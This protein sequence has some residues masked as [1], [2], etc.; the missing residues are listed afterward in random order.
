MWDIVKYTRGTGLDLGCG[1]QKTFPHFIG[2]D[3]C[4]DTQLFGIAMKPDVQVKTCERLDDFEDSACDF[5]FSSHLLEHIED[6]EAALKE[7]W[8][9]IRN[10]GYLVLYLPH[11]LL[12]PNVG[13]ENANPDHKHDFDEAQIKTAMRNVGTG[14]D[15]VEC[16]RRSG[17]DEYSFLMVFQK[18]AYEHNAQISSYM[19]R[20]KPKKSVCVVR[21]GGFGDMLQMACILP[22]LKRQGYH[23]T[24]MTTPRGQSVVEH[25]PNIDVFF[26]QDDDQ[27]PNHLLTDFWAHQA[28]QFD[29]FINLSES[30]EGTLLALP[31]RANHGWSHEMRHKY[32]NL[33]YHEFTAEIAGVP[34]IPEGRFYPAPEEIETVA[35]LLPD[36]HT[37]TLVF[38]LSGSSRHKF[39]PGQDAVIAALLVQIPNIH[40]YLVGDE[41]C[42]ILEQ[43]W[44]NEP[45]VSLL[46]GK[47]TVRETLTLAQRS[48]CVVGP[49]TGVLN[50]VAFDP[51]VGKVCL[52]SHS[53]IENLTKHWENTAS[54]EPPK[55]VKCYP[56]HRLHYT[57][58][59]CDCD[60]AIGAARCQMEI[61]PERVV[62][63]VMVVYREWAAK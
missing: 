23:I 32:L 14:W 46:S 24:V 4:K 25:D 60:E 52:L 30:I 34:F 61:D 35:K 56:C 27:V 45:R 58:Q 49:E 51:S 50:S 41:A 28:K 55:H 21:Y 16:Q 42:K 38:A 17:G 11:K 7:W 5:V 53:S 1:P 29:K 39:Y 37:F 43:G 10:D 57:A 22:Q 9:V 3:N 59:H 47:Q 15:L 13:Q 44:E 8:R 63:A 48:D 40:V 6:Y 54:I 20:Q 36:T 26:I 31:G 2:V 12:Y 62:E 33:N 18:K 19:T